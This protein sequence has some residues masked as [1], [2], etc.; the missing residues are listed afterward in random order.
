M[1]GGLSFKIVYCIYSCHYILGHFSTFWFIL[2]EPYV[3]PVSTSPP[4]F[5]WKMVEMLVSA[6]SEGTPK[7]SSPLDHSSLEGNFVFHIAVVCYIWF[8]GLVQLTSQFSA[9]A[10]MERSPRESASVPQPLSL[11]KSTLQ[12]G[13]H[14]PAPLPSSSF[15]RHPHAIKIVAGPVPSTDKGSVSF[16]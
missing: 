14:S 12:A 16:E 11:M 5:N 7:Q 15:Y 9:A 8:W 10:P 4:S 2:I 13:S 3:A 6:P 1:N